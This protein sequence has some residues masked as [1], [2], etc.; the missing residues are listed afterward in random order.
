MRKNVSVRLL[1]EKLNIYMPITPYLS[2]PARDC[3]LI[4][5]TPGVGDTSPSVANW[6]LPGS[7]GPGWG[8]TSLGHLDDTW[9]I[10]QVPP[11]WCLILLSNFGGTFKI[12]TSGRS[13]QILMRHFAGGEKEW[14]GRPMG[15]SLSPQ[16]QLSLGKV[17]PT[18]TAKWIEWD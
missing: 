7:H 14:W 8:F 15:T 1:R 10:S 17:G 4:P 5:H 3:W 9:K 2:E 18:H 6:L 16:R 12:H 13:K 11:K